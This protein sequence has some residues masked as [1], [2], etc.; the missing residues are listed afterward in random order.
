MWMMI[1]YRVK[2]DQLERHLDLHSAV[3][4]ELESSGVGG[5]REATFQLDDKMSF[6]AF[7]NADTFPVPGTAHLEAFKNYQADLASRCEEPP[8]MTMLH[9]SG[10]YRFN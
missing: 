3:Y 2:P 1:S 4:E 6:V 9:E 8:V 10:S 5:L 7:V